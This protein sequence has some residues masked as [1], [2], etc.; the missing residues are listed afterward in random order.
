MRAIEFLTEIKITQS[1]KGHH[2]Q[3]HDIRLT[4]YTDQGVA[5]YLDY[6]DWHGQIQIQMIQVFQKRQGIGTAL[7]KHLQSL[8]PATEIDW[9]TTS[10]LGTQ[11]YNSLEFEQ[12]PNNSV[13]RMMN[14][15]KELKNQE[16]KYHDLAAQWEQSAKTETDRQK[17]LDATQDWN[18]L[19]DQIYQLEQEIGNQKPYKQLIKI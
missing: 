10:E 16:Q 2:H 6:S 1:V 18:E 11:L 5:G 4:A 12:V 8:Y 17:F 15:L 19:H 13:I 7:V 9:G 3:Q 14:K